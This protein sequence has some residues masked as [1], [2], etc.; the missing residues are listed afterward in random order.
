MNVKVSMIT[1]LL[2]DGTIY[3]GVLFGLNVIQIILYTTDALAYSSLFITLI[4]S[5]LLS[6]FFLNLRQVHSP[7]SSVE[8]TLVTSSHVSDL[9]FA[10][11]VVANMG[12]PLRTG[13]AFSEGADL[14]V[15]I[16]SLDELSS[17]AGSRFAQTDGDEWDASY[18]V[19]RVVKEPLK[20]GLGLLNDEIVLQP[21]ER[22]P[23][24]LTP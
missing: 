4:T 13:P 7:K 2:R 19:P 21:L 12:A 22:D 16:S 1:L 14:S 20:D 3:F 8:D 10:S 24:E 6:R 18:E 23:E 9:H 15:S 5:I 11:G 17:I